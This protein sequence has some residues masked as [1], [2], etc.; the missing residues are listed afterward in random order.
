MLKIYICEHSDAF[1]QT[2][3]MIAVAEDHA[4][5]VAQI[6]EHLEAITQDELDEITAE[7]HELDVSQPLVK[8]VASSDGPY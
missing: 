1:E 5:A 6:V 8:T 2:L 7:T 4:S 3:V